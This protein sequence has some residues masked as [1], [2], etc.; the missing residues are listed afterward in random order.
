MSLHHKHFSAQEREFIRANFRQLTNRQLA[1]QLG[2][3][4]SSITWQLQAMGLTR[5][6]VKR[7]TAEE[8]EE[9]RRLAPTM[10]RKQLAAHFGTTDAGV[11]QAMKTR[12]I[13]TG[14]TGTFKPG[15]IPWSKGMKMPEGWGGATRFKKGSLP[16]NTRQDGDISIRA[17]TSGHKYKYI[18]TSLNRWEL[19]HRVN[20][21]KAYGPIPA[22]MLVAFKDGDQM[23]CDPDNLFLET[24]EQHMKRNTIHRYDPQLRAAIRQLATFKRKIKTY[25]EQ[26]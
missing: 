20:W 6:T 11:K 15:N 9:L 16:H 26:N 25:E 2:R 7:W 24:V 1:G 12:G 5:G 18:R 13:R 3:T 8:A 23:N 17:Y 14:R 21:V 4:E 22:G 10:T 19:L